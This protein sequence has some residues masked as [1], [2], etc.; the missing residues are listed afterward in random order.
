MFVTILDS[1]R[2]SSNCITL[3][4]NLPAFPVQYIGGRLCPNVIKGHSQKNIPNTYF[5]IPFACISLQDLSADA[6]ES[7]N[8]VWLHLEEC[9]SFLTTFDT[10]SLYICNQVW[11][12][13][14][15]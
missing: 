1:Y 14:I 8:K 10:K 3:V 12:E 5:G 7:M 13:S 15:I 9:Q 11:W 6:Q 2:K 4:D